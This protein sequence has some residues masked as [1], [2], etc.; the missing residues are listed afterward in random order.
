MTPFRRFK[1]WE[2]V[3]GE[4][5]DSL[6]CYISVETV[7]VAARK[8]KTKAHTAAAF[9]AAAPKEV[10]PKLNQIRAAIRQAAPNATEY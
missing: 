1:G 3:L 6:I 7:I 10:R 5:S 2:S 8:M 9:I 4:I